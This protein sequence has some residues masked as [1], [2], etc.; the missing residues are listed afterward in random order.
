VI[1]TLELS[2]RKALLRVEKTLPGDDE[3]L[4]LE[5]VFEQRLA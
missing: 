2:G 4:R 1:A 3:E 5:L